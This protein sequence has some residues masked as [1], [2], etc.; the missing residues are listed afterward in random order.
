MCDMQVLDDAVVLCLRGRTL[1][2]CPFQDLRGIDGEEA[3]LRLEQ[4][5][6]RCTQEG[7]ERVEG[8]VA[9]QQDDRVHAKGTQP[10]E[11]VL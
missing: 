2:Q 1:V 10:E 8:R 11:A 4:D 6:P 5:H 3:A 9:A 7:V